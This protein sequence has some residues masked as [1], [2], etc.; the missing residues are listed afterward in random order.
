LFTRPYLKKYPTKKR[1]GGVAQ[2][3]E[4]LPSKC[5]V[6]KSNPRIEKKRHSGEG[7]REG[8]MRK[9]RMGNKSRQSLDSGDTGDPELGLARETQHL[10]VRLLKSQM[11]FSD[12]VFR[13]CPHSWASRGI[14]V[15]TGTS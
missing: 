2:V 5:E 11:V 13:P 6:L 8:R 10:H 4:R 7:R 15:P 1:A 12:S 9:K 3:V 14:Y